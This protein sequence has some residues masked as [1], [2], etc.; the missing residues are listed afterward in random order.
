MMIKRSKHDTIQVEDLDNGFIIRYS[1]YVDSE[2]TDVKLYCKDLDDVAVE[3]AK[4]FAMP[5]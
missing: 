4:Y 1:V 5:T 3:I 2:W